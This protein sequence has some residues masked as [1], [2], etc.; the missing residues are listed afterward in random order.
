VKVPYPTKYGLRDAC[1]VPTPYIHI[2]NRLF[3]VQFSTSE[4]IKTLLAEP[5]DRLGNA[6]TPF[7]KRLARR[8]GGPDGWVPRRLWP[9]LDTVED[10]LARLGIRPEDVDYITYDHLHTQDL[11]KWLGRK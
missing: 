1:T 4:G 10:A 2:C 11:R 5:L 9:A 7:F 3:V 8:L 6:E